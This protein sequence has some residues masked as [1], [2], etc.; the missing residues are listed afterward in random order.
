MREEFRL[1]GV[2]LGVDG[3]RSSVVIGDSGLLTAELSAAATPAGT[4]QWALAPPLLYF[5]GVPLTTAGDTMTLTVDDE[6]LDAYDIALYFIEHRDV[7]GT[8][9]VRPDGLLVFSGF[10][11][12]NGIGPAQ[13]LT[14][15]R[16]LSARHA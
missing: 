5:R 15:S 1:G 8:L 9:T 11:A 12:S 10:V 4:S 16:R 13:R 6:A 14:V 3:D 7:Q 2:D